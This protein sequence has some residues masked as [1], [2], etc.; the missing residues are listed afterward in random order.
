MN[1][2]NVLVR[3]IRL[4]K[5]TFDYQLYIYDKEY[6]ENQK[7]FYVYIHHTVIQL[8][9]STTPHSAHNNHKYWSYYWNWAILY[10]V[11]AKPSTTMC[12][13]QKK[14]SDTHAYHY[15]QKNIIKH[16]SQ[17]YSY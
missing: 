11:T 10:I 4:D 5:H 7:R 9:E 3:H 2:Y 17:T 16:Y 14:S 6:I 15:T 12:N 8:Y 1:C 13:V